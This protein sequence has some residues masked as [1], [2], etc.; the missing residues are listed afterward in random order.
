MPSLHCH[1]PSD[2]VE[3]KPQQQVQ[4]VQEEQENSEV[5]ES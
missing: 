3:R 5:N 4:E 2:E 1:L